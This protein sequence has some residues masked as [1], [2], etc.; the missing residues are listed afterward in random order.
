MEKKAIKQDAGR[1]QL[2][3]FAPKFAE[4]N[5]NM[6]HWHGAA[7]DSWFAHLAMPV[8]GEETSNEWPKPVEDAEYDKLTTQ[9]NE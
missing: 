1:K 5:A 8:P 6:K 4:L 9:P 7:A 3:S 2:D